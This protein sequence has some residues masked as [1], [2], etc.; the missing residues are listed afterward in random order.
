[1]NPAGETF[2]L[3]ALERHLIPAKS[4]DADEARPKRVVEALKNAIRTH[5]NGRPQ[6]D[7]I[8]I[9]CFGRWDPGVDSHSTL[10]GQKA[11]K[12]PPDA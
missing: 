4:D 3:T 5:A 10:N 2:G 1:M 11:D 7:D 6:F 8:A 12:H 9:V